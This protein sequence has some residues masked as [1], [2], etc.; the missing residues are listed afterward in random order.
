MQTLRLPPQTKTSW[1]GLRTKRPVLAA[2]PS[3]WRLVLLF[4]AR[5][6]SSAPLWL[7][8]LLRR[9]SCRRAPLAARAPQKAAKASSHVPRLFHSRVR[10]QEGW[11]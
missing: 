4:R 11:T 3:C 7:I 8:W 1:P 5:A 9:S 2:S 6:S 10:L